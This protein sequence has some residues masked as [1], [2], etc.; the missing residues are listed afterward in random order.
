M[1]NKYKK[2][3]SDDK[4]KDRV[5]NILENIYIDNNKNILS[6]IKKTK[7]YKIITEGY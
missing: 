3:I 1:K 4:I 7:E 5:N 2:Y 6:Y